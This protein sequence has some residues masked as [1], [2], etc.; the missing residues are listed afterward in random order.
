MNYR[1]LKYLHTLFF[2]LGILICAN[3]YAS[4]PMVRNFPKSLHTGG[5]QTWVIS[6]DSLGRMYFGNNN[7][8]LEFDGNRWSLYRLP[9]WST[10]RSFLSDVSPAGGRRIYVGGSEEFGWFDFDAGTGAP[11]YHSLAAFV[12]KSIKNYK[13]IW[14]IHKI[15]ESEAL[16]FQADNVIFRYNGKTLV[17][18][19][20]NERILTSAVAGSRIFLAT[21]GSGL[22][23]LVD[24]RFRHFNNDALPAG[25]RIVSILPF[26]NTV[27]AVTEY[28]G[29]YTLEGGALHPYPTD[30]DPFLKSNQVFCAANSGS[31]YA[32]GTVGM[33]AVIRDIDRR[34][35][36]Y[37]N[38]ETGLQNN[39]V[40]SLYFD[41]DRNLWLGLDNGI[42][43]AMTSLP[44]Y[45][46]LGSSGSI[47]AGYASVLFGGRMFL[48]TNQ[49]LYSLVY[50]T[51]SSAYP[52]KLTPII[53]GQVWEMRNIGT[54]L[55]VCT[56][57]GAYYSSGGSAFTRIPGIEGSWS[58]IE[59]PGYP[60][61]ALVSTY[62]KLHVIHKESGAWRDA[63]ELA[64]FDDI[65]GKLTVAGEYI[66]LPNWLKGM[67]RLRVDPLKRRVVASAFYDRKNGFPSERNLKAAIFKG[68]PIFSTEGGFYRL[69]ADN[70][71]HPDSTVNKLLG[72]GPSPSFHVAPYGD[73]WRVEEKH[74]IRAAVSADGVEKVDSV[75]FAP[76]ASHLIPGSDNFNFVGNNRIIV[77]MQE[78]FFDVDLTEANRSAQT[79]PGPARH[80]YISEIRTYGDSA[81]VFYPKDIPE[82]KIVIPHGQ[83][84]L[85]FQAVLPEYRGGD[86]A[87]LYSFKLD[88]Y[89]S[90]W[91]PYSRSAVKE[92]TRLSEGNYTIRVRAYN[93]FTKVTDETSY[94][95][96]VLAPWHRSTKAKIVIV[97][98]ILAGLWFG[99]RQ[100]ERYSRRA[101]LR[102]EQKKEQELEEMRRS[103][104][105][106]ALE[107]D[108]QIADLKGRQLEQDVKHKAEEL[109]NVTMNVARKNE[110]LLDISQRLDRMQE[111]ADSTVQKELQRIKSLIK[112]NISHDDDW[113]NFLHN[114]DLAYDDFARRLSEMHPG[115]T[116]TELRVCCYLKMGLSSKDIAPLFNISYRSVE[117]TRYRIRR[118]LNMTRDTN[119]TE[120]LQSLK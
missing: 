69:G 15:K 76:M 72:I 42:D 18:I 7:G 95:F 2:S 100:L 52:P 104:A 1:V 24:K 82:Q 64:G 80:V 98:L 39:T 43:L 67:H 35:T 31:L 9:N 101:T 118:K 21:S 106:D 6:S 46:L 62:S 79:S 57:G 117:M 34:A 110:I 44:Y 61:Y 23:E 81:G 113:R 107:K 56:D 119:L 92:Y 50:P 54:D 68:A 73:I 74:I 120:Y 71:M 78:G 36:A 58:A 20:V 10:V 19:R 41:P 26:R 59:I 11:R 111:N 94:E 16:W 65:G 109:S 14:K 22:C 99:Y 13:E 115:L 91:S 77:S 45:S 60:G 55:F 8:L 49:G 90:D 93:T 88:S 47:G 37:A 96:E 32:F 4:Y 70:R 86:N 51:P 108:Y 89:D 87:V 5:T 25:A 33:G 112:K 28:D 12:P 105:R 17:P 66:W 48:G 116:Q 30:L 85:Q 102:M 63:G 114:F 40:L 3:T 27:M 84:S 53:R 38:I 83:N 75:T 103:A 97:L 29:L